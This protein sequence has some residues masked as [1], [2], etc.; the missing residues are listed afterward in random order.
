[1]YTQDYTVYRRHEVY[2]RC[3]YI[4]R[5]AKGGGKK[6]EV[7]SRALARESSFVKNLPLL[8]FRFRS[9]NEKGKQTFPLARL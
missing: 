8:V 4:L 2:T 3:I 1:M 6:G 5:T 7:G 9:E